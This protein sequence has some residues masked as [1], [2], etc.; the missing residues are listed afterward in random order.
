MLPTVDSETI[1]GNANLYQTHQI[2]NQE[3]SN[4]ED[5]AVD[6]D[7]HW[8]ERQSQSQQQDAA[9]PEKRCNCPKEV[10]NMK[11]VIF[12]VVEDIVYEPNLFT[13]V[14]FGAK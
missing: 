10:I 9:K 1:P 7:E 8:A 5:H 13:I 3:S 11:D 6:H 14:F 4:N 12:Y 2:N